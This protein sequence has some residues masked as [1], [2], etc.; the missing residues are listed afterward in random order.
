MKYLMLHWLKIDSR[1]QLKR[2]R[3]DATM[4]TYRQLSFH[5]V[6]R[7]CGA[8]CLSFLPSFESA[9][10]QPDV[11]ISISITASCFPEGVFNSCISWGINLR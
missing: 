11:I 6:S 4:P 3:G 8:T 7:A 10:S 5:A 2:L 1:P 9:F